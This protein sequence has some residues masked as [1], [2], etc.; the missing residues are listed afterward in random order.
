M[1]DDKEVETCQCGT[2]YQPED[3]R[4]RSPDK[5]RFSSSNP[6]FNIHNPLDEDD[7][8]LEASF[9]H[10]PSSLYHYEDP[11]SLLEFARN[12]P[13][14][15]AENNEIILRHVRH[16]EKLERIANATEDPVPPLCFSC[17]KRIQA[18]LKIDKERLEAETARFRE[19]SSEQLS[20]EDSLQRTLRECAAGN[21][22]DELPTDPYERTRQVYLEEISTLQDACENMEDEIRNLQAIYKDQLHT[23]EELDIA[24]D[25]FH[26]SCNDME[27]QVKMFEM[28]QQLLS[29]TLKALSKDM[30][31][32]ENH[33]IVG[34][35]SRMYRLQVDTERGLRYPLVN[36]LRL[37]YRPK[38]DIQWEEIEKAWSMVL[39]L[40]LM[41][42]TAFDYD[43]NEWKIVP[44]TQ[45]SK[46]IH[47]IKDS[48]GQVISIVHNL[49]TRKGNNSK[50]IPSFCELLYEVSIH[51]QKQLDAESTGGLLDGIQLPPLHFPVSKNMFGDVAFNHI[52]GDDDSGW[53]KLIHI[54]ASNLLWLSNVTSIYCTEK[55]SLQS[56]V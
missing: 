18:A 44:L 37:A 54:I 35:P 46:L 30:E 16:L 45:A 50:A 48:K 51:V 5:N 1:A 43:S 22:D 23:L 3:E 20:R 34:I 19:I 40:L 2:N 27:V 47:Y 31:D 26:Q 10:L 55:I 9:V 41:I 13:G 15:L 32:L 42:A 56:L 39:Q 29:R 28:D 7:R 33:D 49:G 52:A 25:E 4:S 14:R 12:S 24:N 53:A 36:D 17:V 8:K 38:G 6:E 11:T 21:E